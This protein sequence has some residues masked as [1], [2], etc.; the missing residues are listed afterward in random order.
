[1]KIHIN[2]FLRIKK[3]GVLLLICIMTFACTVSEKPEFRSIESIQ[4]TKA[5]SK[6]ITLRADAIFYNPNDVG[7]T[8]S[9][10]ALHVIINDSKMI[11]F[12]SETFDVPQK[13]T[14]KIPLTVDI[15]TDSIINK[16]SLGGLISSIISQEMKVQYKGDINYKVLG[17]SSSYEVDK[18]ET[19]K[20]KF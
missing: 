16:K 9:T 6:M 12:K 2:S 15:S 20:I 3:S 1:M 4:I 10:D 13:E 18:T 17:F 14:F 11:K 8:L 7:G 19:V 5:N